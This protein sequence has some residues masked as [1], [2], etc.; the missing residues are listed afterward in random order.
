MER[1]SATAISKRSTIRMDTT[2]SL[3]KDKTSS[4]PIHVRTVSPAAFS[5]PWERARLFGI[6]RRLCRADVPSMLLA[7]A[8]G[9]WSPQ[10]DARHKT[11]GPH[12]SPG[13]PRQTHYT[14][15]QISHESFHLPSSWAPQGN[16]GTSSSRLPSRIVSDARRHP[17]SCDKSCVVAEKPVCCVTRKASCRVLYRSYVIIYT[18]TYPQTRM[19]HD[20]C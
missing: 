14:D 9:C 13:V 20:G 5:R 16:A 15:L 10:A 19:D 7:A 3:T 2:D 18:V 12:A 17:Y 8:A 4:T 6:V 1:A 11:K